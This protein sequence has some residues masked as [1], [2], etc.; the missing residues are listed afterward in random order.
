[1]VGGGHADIA[2]TLA[3]AALHTG[4]GLCVI[5]LDPL[6]HGSSALV[7][8][9]TAAVLEPYGLDLDSVVMLS[10]DTAS[11]VAAAVDNAD[12][13]EPFDGWPEPWDLHGTTSELAAGSRLD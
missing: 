10:G 13:A 1:M 7:V 12:N 6:P 9:G 5:A 3:T 11:A 2:R 4:S 8:V